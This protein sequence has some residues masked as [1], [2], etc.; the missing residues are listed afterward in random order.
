M[1]IV[2]NGS[3]SNEVFLE[4]LNGL[5]DSSGYQNALISILAYVEIYGYCCFLRPGRSVLRVIF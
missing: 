5:C 3:L 1:G 2:I 4:S